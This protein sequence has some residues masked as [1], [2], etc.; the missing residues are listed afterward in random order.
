MLALKTA[1]VLHTAYYSAVAL[2]RYGG[3]TA[4]LSSPFI[5]HPEILEPTDIALFV[6]VLQFHSMKHCFC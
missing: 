2:L 5:D 6:P 3:H 4:T 1:G